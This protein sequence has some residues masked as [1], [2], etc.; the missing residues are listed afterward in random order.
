MR[1]SAAADRFARTCLAE[2]DG[3]LRARRME[4]NHGLAFPESNLQ[5]QR[6]LVKARRAMDIA[7]VQVDVIQ[8]TRCDHGV[9]SSSVALPPSFYEA[10]G[11]ET[12]AAVSNTCSR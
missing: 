10:A 2:G 12:G 7:D 3:I 4:K 6:F 8:H 11:C 9:T 5:S 1:H